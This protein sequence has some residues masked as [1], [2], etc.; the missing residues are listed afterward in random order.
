MPVSLKFAYSRIISPS[1]CPFSYFSFR[2][3]ITIPVFSIIFS[4][5]P[6]STL[7]AK[8]LSGTFAPRLSR[9]RLPTNPPIISTA[10]IS[11]IT[12]FN[13]SIFGFGIFLISATLFCVLSLLSI[14]CI[15]LIL[16]RDSLYHFFAFF[17]RFWYNEGNYKF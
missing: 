3:R 15:D 8:S 10:T 11:V 1:P 14:I 5:S 12:K 17:T 2:S 6:F 4:Y 9:R 7:P 16:I 13:F